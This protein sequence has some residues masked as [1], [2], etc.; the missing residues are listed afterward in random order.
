MAV[1]TLGWE[2]SRALQLLSDVIVKTEDKKKREALRT[3]H[4]K[5]AKRLQT[6]ID[7]TVPTTI[8]QYDQVIAAL[9][10]ANQALEAAREDIE[11][12]D[13]AIRKVGRVVRLLGGLVKAMA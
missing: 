3:Q 6:L 7:Q 2:L 13:Q 12:V 8:K 11:K 5:L 1:R 9:D 10:E 4:R